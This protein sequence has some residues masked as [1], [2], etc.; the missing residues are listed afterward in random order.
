MA[1]ILGKAA[2]ACNLGALFSCS[3]RF[4]AGPVLRSC[5]IHGCRYPAVTL[6]VQEH[7]ARNT[8]AFRETV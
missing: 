1:S 8:E 2:Y 7:D 3:C 5:S 4:R 6:L